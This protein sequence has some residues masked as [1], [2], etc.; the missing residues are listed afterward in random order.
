MKVRKGDAAIKKEPQL[1]RIT[2]DVVCP[3]GHKST[4]AQPSLR[5]YGGCM[6]HC[7]G[8]YCYCDP[9]R[10]ELGFECEHEECRHAWYEIEL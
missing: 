1:L 2:A 8:D 10:I 5:A 9:P 4:V 3:K 6:G 7:Q